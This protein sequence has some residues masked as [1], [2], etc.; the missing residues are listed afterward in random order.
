MRNHL[1][2]NPFIVYS[3]IWCVVLAVYQLNWSYLIPP[4]SVEYKVFL[5]STIFISFVT[6]LLFHEKRIFTYRPINTPNLRWLKKIYIGLYILL[7]V[8]FVY[9]RGIP[10]LGYITGDKSILYTEFGLPIVHVAIVNSLNLLFI[11]LF[12]C[13][14]STSNKKSKRT[15]LFYLFLSILPFILIFSRM[16]I[17]VCFIGGIIIYLMSI[18]HVFKVLL[19]TIILVL[20][21][22]LMFG[23][24][25]NLRTDTA[26]AKDLILDIGEATPEFRNSMIPDEF[27]WGYLYIASPLG[28]SQYAINQSPQVDA[29]VNSFKSF[30]LFELTPQ[31][32][33]KRIASQFKIEQKE[34]ILMTPSLNVS[35]VYNGAYQYLSWWGM[36]LIYF[37]MYIFIIASI[38]LVPKR[39][40]FYTST[41][42]VIDAIIIL[43]LFTNMFVFMGLVPQVFIAILLSLKYLRK[44][45]CKKL[46][47][48]D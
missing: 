47:F 39:S 46:V 13:Y 9:A 1:I 17:L 22:L 31:I 37:F 41:I 11:Y 33:S 20:L 27:F 16:G 42:V 43:N 21:M 10:L 35:S 8:E 38:S 12:H 30:A 29:D 48:F 4:L 45:Y 36:I 7:F 25:G 15:L 32:I 24:A 44:R 18:Q 14:R 19:K 40:P 5:W 6:G 28:N 2:V 23:Y 26:A 34:P 3:L